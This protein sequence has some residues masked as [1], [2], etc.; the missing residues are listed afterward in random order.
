MPDEG[1]VTQDVGWTEEATL[2]VVNSV[3]DLSS[4]AGQDHGT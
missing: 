4:G 2:E 1:V 3:H